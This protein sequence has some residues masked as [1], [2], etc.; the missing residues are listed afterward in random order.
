MLLVEEPTS[1]H[2]RPPLE[3]VH[4]GDFMPALVMQREVL[5]EWEAEAF[6]EEAEEA[7]DKIFES[8]SDRDICMLS[9]Q[10]TNF[11]IHLHTT[12]RRASSNVPGRISLQ[13]AVKNVSMSKTLPSFE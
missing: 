13:S 4:P 11:A 3:K 10:I 7:E 2:L 9:L 5:G 8:H 12:L 1:S 6:R